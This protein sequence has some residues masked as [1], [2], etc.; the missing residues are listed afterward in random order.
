MVFH[1]LT[2]TGGLEVNPRCPRRCHSSRCK[3]G[4][5][6]DENQRA[7]YARLDSI[8]GLPARARPRL[9]AATIS[10]S[11][12]T[13]SFGLK[14]FRSRMSF[15]APSTTD[16]D[17]E[18]S[19]R[20]SSAIAGSTGDARR[21]SARRF[22]CGAAPPWLR[23]TLAPRIAD[24]PHCWPA[25]F[26][27]VTPPSRE[28]SIALPHPHLAEVV[29]ELLPAVQ[30]YDV[31]L[32]MRLA[33]F[34]NGCDWPG[35]AAVGTPEQEVQETVDHIRGPLPLFSQGALRRCSQPG[36]GAPSRDPDDERKAV[37]SMTSPSEYGL[38]TVVPLWS[39]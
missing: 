19:R 14:P 3:R 37:A 22:T 31:T 20:P 33:P 16:G 10:P 26:V 24:F 25:R 8:G 38:K 2:F 9:S 35:E 6:P 18:R 13:T 30:A 28:W 32:A 1:K 11:T 29:L 21:S 34:G 5:V 36:P 12:T 7:T 17:F 39:Q 4:A 15:T 27:A 23:Q